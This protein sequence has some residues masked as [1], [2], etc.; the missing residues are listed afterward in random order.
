[1]GNN[2]FYGDIPEEL[3]NLRY[4][5]A[6]WL[7]GSDLTGCIPD[8]LREVPD[9]DFAASG[10]PF[11]AEIAQART[12]EPEVTP[13][14][15]A[16]PK[17][18]ST[19]VPAVADGSDR[20]ALIAFYEATG[21]PFWKDDTNWLS[22]A[23]LDQW[24]GVVTDNDG[25]VTEIRLLDNRLSG[26]IPAE[27]SYLTSLRRLGLYRNSLAGPIPSELGTL[28]NLEYVDLGGNRLSGEIPPQL[29]DLTQLEHLE[30]WDNPLDGVLPRELGNLTRLRILWLRG[31]RLS[32]VIPPELSNLVALE[33]LG[34]QD[35][36]LTGTTPSWLG[37]LSRLTRLELGG[38]R[39]SGEMPVVF[40]DRTLA[41][42]ELLSWVADGLSA[43]ERDEYGQLV[44]SVD[45]YPLGVATVLAKGWLEDGVTATELALMKHLG[46]LPPDVLAAVIEMPFLLSVDPADPNAVAALRNLE[47][48]DRDSFERIMA[49]PTIADGIDDDEAKIV[50]FLYGTN[51]YR[52]ELVEPLLSGT[53]IYIEERT[54]ELPLAGE[55]LL[56]LVRIRNQPNQLMDYWETAV[57]HMEMFVGEPFPTNYVALLLPQQSPY[58]EPEG[59]WPG[60]HTTVS[61]RYDEEYW[62]D[63]QSGE[64]Y[65]GVLAHELGHYYFGAWGRM[66]SWMAEGAAQF[67]GDTLSEHVRAGKPVTTSMAPCQSATT[68]AELD[69]REIFQ[70]GSI[71]DRRSDIKNAEEGGSPKVDDRW[72]CN[73]TLGERLFLDLYNGLGKDNFHR[74]TSANPLTRVPTWPGQPL[75]EDS[76]RRSRRRL[77]GHLCADMSPAGSVHDPSFRRG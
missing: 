18:S 13:N 30:L 47:R 71:N 38:N 12:P 33:T 59:V 76:A 75:P 54:I 4:L 63:P 3:G 74:C 15:T 27:L 9:N 39:L 65:A 50:T 41:A 6:L 26:R 58:D 42:V 24:Y 55:T 67:L 43:G 25:R 29:G 31:N 62:Q 2:R 77:R 52:S 32:G 10:L 14:P 45:Q 60:T 23:P 49:H 8:E 70:P 69:A 22:D 36:R 40:K 44:T 56:V 72:L 35:N 68:I 19:R 73:Y 11:C 34:L 17:P 21:G 37:D 48:N 53:G 61:I 57:R 46:Q 66:P 28:A 5:R 1:M 51:K 16:I 64:S 7:G 20:D